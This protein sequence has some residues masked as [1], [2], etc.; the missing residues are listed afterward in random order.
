MN[1][2]SGKH[3]NVVRQNSRSQPK[4]SSGR[5]SIPAKAKSK[6]LKR[7]KLCTILLSGALIITVAALLFFKLCFNK[8]SLSGRW[9]LDGVRYYSFNGDGN[10]LLELPENSYAFTYSING[11]VLSI[12][13][14]NENIR[15]FTYD[16]KVNGK[17]LTLVGGEGDKKISYDLSKTK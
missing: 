11:D 7:F 3:R 6:R 16:F 10:G 5:H 17:K 15:D 13:F 2:H 1:N 4:D 9:D 12:D 8:Y 14:E